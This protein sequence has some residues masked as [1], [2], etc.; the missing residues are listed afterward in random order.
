ML[1]RRFLVLYGS[2]TGTAQDVAE[3]I[4]RQARRYRFSVSVLAMD[5]YPVTEL[6]KEKLV[7]FVCATTGQGEEPD[8]MKCFWSFL[9]RK[10]LPLNSLQAMRHCVI[11]LGDSSYL[12]FNFTAKRLYRRLGQLG[13]QC[14]LDP[15][16]ADEQHE[17]GVD[18]MLDPWLVE[19][20]KIV[21]D[22]YPLPN[23]CLPV[24]EEILPAPKYAINCDT[25]SVVTPRLSNEKLF[26]ATVV[27]NQRVTSP[28]HFQDVRLIKLNI[29][30]SGMTFE[31]GDVVVVYPENCE[32]DIDEFF[33][34]FSLKADMHITLAPMEEGTPFP[35][36][37]AAPF[38]LDICV[39]KYFDLTYIP[40]RSFFEL[41]WHFGGSDLEK[42]RLREFSTTGGQEDLVEYAI[43]PRRTVL[44]VF[45]D[46]PHTT[47]N[48]PL[49]YLFDLIPP[50]RP[51][52]FSIANS[53]RYHPGQIHILAAIVNFRTKLKKPRRGLCTR[54]LAS[55]EPTRQPSLT[56]TTR[57]GSLRMPPDDVPAIM[58]GPGTGCAPFCGII[59]DRAQRGI[60]RNLLFFGCR[61]AKNDFFFEKEWTQLGANGLLDLVTAFSR[62]QDHKIYVQHRIAEHEDKVW[63]L[64]CNGGVLYIA[65][66][67]KD[68][69]PSVRD[70]FKAVVKRSGSL[71]DENAE[72][73]LKNLEKSRRLQIEAWS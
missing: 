25:A 58:V 24:S 68:M 44:E 39:R 54:F 30:G 40:K 51:R 46:F 20:W 56:V 50:I 16:Y 11:G 67:A 26:N 2:Q 8:N 27:C 63:Q 43:R 28:D 18:G 19:F 14:L 49:A 3:R 23:G 12:K 73:L 21:M 9:L 48:V 42:E 6:I 33:R 64:L 65:G 38:S 32:E 71:T 5:D 37:L 72:E 61:N 13:A 55:L 7:V 4:G 15:L 10:S 59:Q 41:F 36:F 1:G 57:K 35:H 17:L 34:L 45:T 69:V 66:N 22:L 52:Y 47:A 29:E 31:P 70:A 60:S 62:D 53:L